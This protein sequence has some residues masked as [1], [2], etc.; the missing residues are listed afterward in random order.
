MKPGA[1]NMDE[2]AN[3]HVSRNEV[4]LVDKKTKDIQWTKQNCIDSRHNMSFMSG[5]QLGFKYKPLQD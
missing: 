4:P 3:R 2:L 1:Q 5:S